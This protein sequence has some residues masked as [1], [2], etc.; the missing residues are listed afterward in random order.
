M[1]QMLQNQNVPKEQQTWN[2][3]LVYYRYKLDL[4]KTDLRENLGFSESSYLFLSMRMHCLE[5]K[6]G[7]TPEQRQD[8]DAV[9]DL[10]FVFL[11]KTLQD[12]PARSECLS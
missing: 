8:D 7:C 11:K 10:L 12:E 3:I 4:W 2:I 5:G 1:L 6:E 9:W